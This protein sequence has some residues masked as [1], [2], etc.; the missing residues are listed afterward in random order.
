MVVP[1]EHDFWADSLLELQYRYAS[2]L[3]KVP[4]RTSF[5]DV[6]TCLSTIKVLHL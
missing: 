5:P 2:N 3:P 6:P 4:F 1:V